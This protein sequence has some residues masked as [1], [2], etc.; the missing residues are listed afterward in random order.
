MRT[1]DHHLVVGL[2]RDTRRLIKLAAASL[3]NEIEN[4]GIEGG[5]YGAVGVKAKHLRVQITAT[6]GPYEYRVAKNIL[7]VTLENV[8]ALGGGRSTGH[9]RFQGA[10]WSELLDEAAI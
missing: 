6:R 2:E 7:T 5:V 1:N 9:R 4:R 10:S 8:G 3:P